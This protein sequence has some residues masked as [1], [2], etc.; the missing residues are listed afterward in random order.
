MSGGQYSREEIERGIAKIFGVI[1]PVVTPFNEDDEVDFG[2]FIEE[3]RRFRNTG[4]NGVAVG[5]S[6][7]EGYALTDEEFKRIVEAAAELRDSNF[8]VIAGIIVNSVYQAIRRALMIKDLGVDAIMVTP[9]HYLFNAGD[10]GNY[11]FY[12]RIYE[13][14]GMPIIVYNVVPWNV[15]SVDVLEKLARERVIVSVKQSGGDIHALGELLIRVR[16]APILTALDDMLYPSFVMGASGSIAAVNTI[17]PRTSVRLFNS[18]LRNDH[19]TA[20]YLHERILPIAHSV[21]QQPDMPTRIKYIMNNAEWRVG[22][23]RKPLPQEPRQDVKDELLKLAKQVKELE[24][25]N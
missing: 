22:Y 15:V 19:K 5:G 12:R 23:P 7:G 10:E 18:V 11:L 16:D 3:L 14:T 24:E 1:P 21:I 6:T 4:V 20:R 8:L 2:L 25:S 13:R 17:L 9:P